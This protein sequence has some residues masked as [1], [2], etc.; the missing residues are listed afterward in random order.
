MKIGNILKT[1]FSYSITL[2]Q[3]VPLLFVSEHA[4]VIYIMDCRV[5]VVFFNIKIITNVLSVFALKDQN[6]GEVFKLTYSK[7]F[8][9][10]LSILDTPHT[11]QVQFLLNSLLLII[12]WR[13]SKAESVKKTSSSS[14]LR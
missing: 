12:P 2:V 14:A 11:Y 7:L 10:F 8:F 3:K 5:F 13:P 1:D 9:L 4:T 6:H